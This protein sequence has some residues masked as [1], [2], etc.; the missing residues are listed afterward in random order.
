MG[1]SKDYIT[2]DGDNSG[3]K[4]LD[5]LYTA[6]QIENKI[7]SIYFD[8]SSASSSLTLGGYNAS[9]IAPG[10][11]LTF[12]KTPYS[13]KWELSINAIKVGENPTFPNGAKT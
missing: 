7:F 3:S 1:L 11:S 10:H 12:L 9:F 5:S 2:A 13:K 4:F 8:P 6:D